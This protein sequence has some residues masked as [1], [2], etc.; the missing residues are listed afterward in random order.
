MTHVETGRTKR[1]ILLTLTLGCVVGIFAARLPGGS[2]ISKGKQVTVEKKSQPEQKT[3]KQKAK[4]AAEGEAEWYFKPTRE[5]AMFEQEEYPLTDGSTSAEPIGVM[6]ACELTTTPCAWHPRKPGE[7]NKDLSAPRERRLLPLDPSRK[8]SNP[9]VRLVGQWYW[10]RLRHDGTHGAYK[11]LITG[12]E[13]V[14]DGSNLRKVR[15]AL[16][17]ECRKPSADERKLMAKHEVDL[18]AMPIAL[19][20]FVFIVNE[21]N[22][23][24]GLTLEQVRDIYTGKI[25]NWKEVG[26]KDAKINAYVRNRNSGS[27]ETMQTLVMKDLKITV[28]QSMI[29]MTMIEMTMMGPYNLIS[30][31]PNGIGFTFA[32][33][34][35]D[36]S[37][38]PRVKTLAIGGVEP[39]PKTFASRK[40]PLT[41]E[42]L[43]VWRSDLAEDAPGR[44][45]L[46]W[47]KTK[48]AQKAISRCGYVPYDRKQA[49]ETWK[50]SKKTADA[51]TLEMRQASAAIHRV[52][53][54]MD[55]KTIDDAVSA[56]RDH[57]R[58]FDSPAFLRLVLPDLMRLA[59]REIP[60]RRLLRTA[61]DKGWIDGLQ[62]RG[63]L[64]RAGDTAAPHIKALLA[65]LK[66]DEKA[67]RLR[68]IKA[69]AICGPAAKKAL[70]ELR[71]IANAPDAKPEDFARAYTATHEAPE[72]VRARWAIWQIEPA[73]EEESVK[74]AK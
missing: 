6:V 73:D 39:G 24:K 72:H 23:V 62:A 57:I 37:N 67:T 33:F 38:T 74:Q 35:R 36:R 48:A 61:R 40:Y 49:V 70:P 51:L 43:A 34:H 8:A 69:L 63:L 60:T 5:K 16:I 27:Q 45:V 13:S 7:R 4:N 65:A 59:P 55:R 53:S 31:D 10:K 42:V 3:E 66:S 58:K 9:D 2:K 22:A 46:A 29:E 25:K 56:L 20:G 68:A 52:H 26:G 64:V 28:G 1:T 30:R 44:K 14:A 54:G 47:L 17:Y 19:D 21:K 15:P 11:R 18:Q 71:A 41:T 12:Q 32:T 50:A